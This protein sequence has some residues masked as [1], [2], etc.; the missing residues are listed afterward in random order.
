[1]KKEKRKKLKGFTDI[2]NLLDHLD[3]EERHRKRVEWLENQK[4][5]GGEKNENNR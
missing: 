2:G 4:K 5:K 1:M 3:V